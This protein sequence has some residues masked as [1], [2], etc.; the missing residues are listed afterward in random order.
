MA[1]SREWIDINGLMR[2]A[3]SIVESLFKSKGLYLNFSAAEDLPQVY[4]D[5][6]ASAR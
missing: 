3:L 6:P 5:R 2:E 1:L 4:C